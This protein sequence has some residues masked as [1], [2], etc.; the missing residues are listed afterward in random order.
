MFE[1]IVQQFHEDMQTAL[2]HATQTLQEQN[3]FGAVEETL[4]QL[5]D[6]LATDVLTGL[7]NDH[8]RT[9]EFLTQVKALGSQYGLRFKGYRELSVYLFTGQRV[10]VMS[11]YFLPKQKKRGRKKRGP[12]GRGRH[13]GLE[14]LGFIKRGSPHF[15]NEV[16]KLAVLCPSFAVTKEVLKD[17]R[18]H[19][20]VKTI[21]R[22][23]RDLGAV[24]M[25]E[26]G[27]ISV[28][29]NED[30]TGQT[31][32]VSVDGGR[33]RTRQ[34]KRGRKKHGQQR[35][36]YRTPW[37]EPLLFT[38]YALDADGKMS[39]TFTPIH[40]ATMEDYDACFALLRRYLHGENR[41]GKASGF[42][43][44]NDPC[45]LLVHW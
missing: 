6:T 14:V 21:R 39:K 33:V 1:K 7:L 28:Q 26:R 13:L 18:I 12:N 35:Q 32:V 11:P 31:L 10:S 40:D 8:L 41:S 2:T 36:G 22:Y 44:E 27:A 16:V 24:G 20:N 15:V 30:L 17:R 29:A 3:D 25:A 23:C 19:L 9:P 45:G 43:V 4:A 42:R 37:K 34:P 5:L 38:L